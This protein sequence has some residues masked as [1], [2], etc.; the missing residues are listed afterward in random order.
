MNI[1]PPLLCLCFA[2]AFGSL[3][4]SS[5]S[6]GPPQLGETTVFEN[7]AAL[8]SGGI[9]SLAS[10]DKAPPMVRGRVSS[11]SLLSDELLFEILPWQ[12]WAAVS[13]IVDWSSSTPI[14]GKVPQTIHRTSGTSED[15]IGLSSS[16]IV[17]SNFNNAL[18]S[19]QLRN[20]GAE[21]YVLEAQTTFEELFTEWQ[22]LGDFIDCTANTT[23]K[24][25]ELRQEIRAIKSLA[26]DIF[27]TS[28]AK[29]GRHRALLMQG[30]FSYGPD[31]IQGDCLRMAG[32]ENALSGEDFGPNP[33]L[34][35][36]LLVQLAPDYIFVAGQTE[37]PRR[38]QLADLPVGIPWS[39]IHAVQNSQVF[40]VPGSWMASIS[41]HALSA[42]RAY[43]ESHAL[44]REKALL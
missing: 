23:K 13:Y 14:A 36:E 3:G 6:A 30:M 43:A 42:C 32:F 8:S 11:A 40:M 27:P 37:A 19:F 4:V 7:A 2:A 24:L 18:T 33:Q 21:L 9:R 22:K 16:L 5:L 25:A 1:A 39:G 15:L 41:H 12:R 29:Q 28:G 26:S 20:A 10:G 31:T 44:P 34:N 38:A 35:V 17:V